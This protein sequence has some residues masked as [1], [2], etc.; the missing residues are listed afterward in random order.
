MNRYI[1]SIL[2]ILLLCC[3]GCAGGTPTETTAPTD[4]AA[5]DADFIPT[6]LV[7]TW[8]SASSGE[9]DMTET[10]TF[11][12]DGTLSAYAIYRGTETPTVGGSFA[13]SGHTLLCEISEGVNEPYTV[14]YE[15]RIDGRE[16]YLTDDEGDSHFLRVS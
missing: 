2:L 10:F 13:V 16:L 5:T 6:E 12:E 3:S 9:L 4:T 1:I 11:N 7:G 15:F 8:T 14:T